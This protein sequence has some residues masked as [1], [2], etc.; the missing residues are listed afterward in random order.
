MA[1]ASKA[2]Q[3]K[4][5]NTFFLLAGSM[6]WELWTHKTKGG[7]YVVVSS[8]IMIKPAPDM[9]FSS[10]VL[11]TDGTHVFSRTKENFDDRFVKVQ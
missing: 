3:R 11:Y 6:N 10:G 1:K 9:A 8:S 4:F 7:E 5:R 2:F